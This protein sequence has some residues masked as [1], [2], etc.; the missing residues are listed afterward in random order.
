MEVT[1]AGNMNIET[2]R[3]RLESISPPLAAA[4]VAGRRTTTQDRW[5]PDY[6]LVDELDPL[7]ALAGNP[8][9][10]PVFTM[11][12]IRQASDG[13]AIGGLG[14]FGPPDDSGRVEIGYGLVPTARGAG[15]ATEAVIAALRVAAGR[16]ATAVAADTEND[17]G[18]SQR[19]LL[20]AGFI[21]VR[22][23]QQATFFARPLGSP[24]S[25]APPVVYEIDGSA[26]NNLDDLYRPI[27]EAV[28]G[29]DGY[30]GAN[31]D[32]LDDCL[33]G[34]RRLPG[35]WIRHTRGRQSHAP[36]PPQQPRHQGSW[37]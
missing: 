10:D 13:L 11:Y 6:P 34:A 14:F 16:S 36:T 22:R 28:N 27:G 17:N 35:R 4:I 2:P 33:G 19:V 32:A 9:P 23:N 18:A 12:M 29:P 3:L 26:I 24:F 25:P 8:L 30:F 7:Q 1:A 5:H 37:F 21:E 20:K 31:L 15:L